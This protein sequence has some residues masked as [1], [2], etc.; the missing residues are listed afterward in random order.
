MDATSTSKTTVRRTVATAALAA[1]LA[2]TGCQTSVNTHPNP[3]PAEQPPQAP[4]GIDTNRPV[5]RVAE[6]I[7]RDNERVT[8][9][10]K[11]FKGTPADRVTE[12]LAREAGAQR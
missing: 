9:L 8:E 7:E 5:D 10:S 1:G 11:R 12:T 6:V 2:L 4:G 3:V